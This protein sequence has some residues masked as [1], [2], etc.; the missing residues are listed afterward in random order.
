MRPRAR[1]SG[2]W[3]RLIRVGLSEVTEREQGEL[4]LR[5]VLSG[6]KFHSH[7]ALRPGRL[8]EETLGSNWKF[9]R[10]LDVKFHVYEMNTVVP[11]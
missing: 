1:E 2:S 5:V 7:P 6:R 3:R 8:I 9:Y 11:Q 4:G 10:F